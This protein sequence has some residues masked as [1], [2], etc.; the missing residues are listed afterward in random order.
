[1]NII[2]RPDDFSLAF[3]KQSTPEK[4][5][6][7]YFIVFDEEVKTDDWLNDA[8]NGF[9][10]RQVLNV[11][12]LFGSSTTLKIASYNPFLLE[13]IIHF[14]A[15]ETNSDILFMDKTRNLYGMELNATVFLEKSGF[16]F[17]SKQ[18]YLDN[19]YETFDGAHGLFTRTVLSR[20]NA[21]LRLFKLHDKNFDKFNENGSTTGMF[22]LLIQKMATVGF[23]T[24]LY[25]FEHFKNKLEFS[26][27]IGRDDLC[28]LVP[29]PGLRPE[30]GS[31]FR[32]FSR[33]AWFLIIFT[34]L[35]FKVL[36]K[37]L[38]KF[39][40]NR[41]QQRLEMFDFIGWCLKKSIRIIAKDWFTRIIILTWVTY[42]FFIVSFYEG[43]L[44]R[45]LIMNPRKPP[46]LNTI[47]QWEQSYLVIR[48]D[49]RYNDDAKNY[50][51]HFNRTHMV[52]KL[53]VNPVREYFHI[54]LDNE[55]NSEFAHHHHINFHIRMN[56]RRN[57]PTR[58]NEMKTCISPRLS[59][60]FYSY[61]SVYRNRINTHLRWA[62]ESGLATKWSERFSTERLK[63]R[64]LLSG[65]LFI[66]FS[67]THLQTVFILY[68]GGCLVG[69]IVF[70][71]EHLK[72]WD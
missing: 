57:F 30:L 12:I 46:H 13:K 40:Y 37:I 24:R 21:S 15:N 22:N 38:V 16:H 51:I 3:V 2:R 17:H 64:D 63:P 29:K 71:V 7:Y 62:I 55:P 8:F 49:G 11:L 18:K 69:L 56:T 66:P 33:N 31:I 52:Q 39:K 50:F 35:A 61:G 9:W 58:L 47:Q 5:R 68:I 25:R 42:S 48:K 60:F 19:F 32:S 27:V 54:P 53:K 65:T 28:I 43:K 34:I 72:I 4:H 45:N 1:M 59:G 6:A 44:T 26:H 20:M 67:V 36:Y 10:H 14:N 70:L 23:N 41:Q